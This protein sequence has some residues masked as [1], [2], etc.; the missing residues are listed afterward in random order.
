MNISICPQI[1][2]IILSNNN[3]ML[4]SQSKLYANIRS[5]LGGS[6]RLY[7]NNPTAVMIK[8]DG[9]C[10]YKITVISYHKVNC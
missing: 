3:G 4:P 5:G 6:Q 2:I 9:N 7:I 1:Y 10:Q 8:F